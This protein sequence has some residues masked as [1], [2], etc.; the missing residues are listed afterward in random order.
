MLAPGLRRILAATAVLGAVAGCGQNPQFRM[1]LANRAYGS[2]GELYVLLAKADLGALRSPS[3]FAGEVDS[4]AAILG[5]FEVG[6]LMA[7]DHASGDD[8]NKAIQQCVGQVRQMSDAHRTAGI[9]PGSARIRTVRISCDDAARLVAANE[10]S[11]W[12]FSTA[13]ADL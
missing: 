5:G 3:S 4:Y 10:V 12:I 9:A 7:K 1:N 13:A 11:S 6:R 2:L 8:L